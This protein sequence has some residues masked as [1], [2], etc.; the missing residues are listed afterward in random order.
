MRMCGFILLALLAAAVA[1]AE[2]GA[3]QAAAISPS[4]PQS[5]IVFDTT[6][7]AVVTVR[8]LAGVGSAESVVGLDVRPSTGQLYALS[9]ATGSAANSAVHTYAVDPTT[10]AATLVGQTGVGLAGA[11]DVPSGID[12]NPKVDRLRLVNT[13]DENARID[14]V[15]GDLAGNDPDVTPAVTV[16]LIAIAYD[17]NT[18]ESGPT[19][20]YGI[21]RITSQ[22][23]I[24]G[25]IDG[26]PSPNSGVATPV[27]SLGFTLD[28]ASDGGFDV[29]PG[30]TAYATLTSDVDDEPR[31]YTIDL[32]SGAATPVGE[33]PLALHSLAILPPVAPPVDAVPPAALFDTGGSPRIRTLQGAG[34][35]IAFS[36]DEACSASAV[37][38]AR[39]I[40][41][42]G[43][44]GSIPAGGVGTLTI[45]P[46]ID[47]VAILR[48]ARR[49][50][51]LEALLTVTFT[52]GAGNGTT[53]EQLL[54]LRR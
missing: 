42:A 3:E 30:G 28:P 7:P 48:R 17:R 20:L 29:A 9:V 46:R 15:D 6:A 2:V 34:L 49:A 35:P 26:T 5:L 11:G 18:T 39:G 1:P 32:A 14:P 52:D 47:G 24:Q 27:G 8:T 19:T 40:V 44:L 23:V 54:Y 16:A 31:L 4:L 45:L 33:L 50:G 21:N 13:N 43:G 36:C 12:F 51:R 37:L 53:R 22:L 10:G 41:V 25:G 38:A